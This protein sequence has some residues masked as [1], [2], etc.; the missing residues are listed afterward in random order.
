MN[1]ETLISVLLL[2]VSAAF[3]M[4]SHRVD[5]NKSNNNTDQM[6]KS[7]ETYVGPFYSQAPQRYPSDQGTVI[8]ATHL[9]N[10][11]GAEVVSSLAIKRCN[12]TAIEDGNLNV[13]PAANGMVSGAG[14]VGGGTDV[15]DGFWN[16]AY[17]GA[18]AVNVTDTVQDITNQRTFGSTVPTV[19]IGQ[20]SRYTQMTGEDSSM[21]S[22]SFDTSINDHGP[23]S[24]FG[25][26]SGSAPI[27][28]L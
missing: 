1:N 21:P 15:L 18:G 13:T 4:Y 5:T 23:L 22:T 24:I 8:P 16:Q 25:Y 9:T 3:F 19:H 11:P 26:T 6:S 17:Q 10:V 12:S 2:C 28:G 20:T 7:G 14:G 27:L